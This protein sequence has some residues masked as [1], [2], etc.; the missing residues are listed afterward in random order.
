MFLAQNI[1][2]VED[3]HL[4]AL[5]LAQTVVEQGGHVVGSCATVGDALVMLDRH[6]IDGAILDGTLP[7]GE[8]TPVALRLADRGI[9]M[10]VYSGTGLPTGLAGRF[11]NLPVVFKPAS[12]ATVLAGLAREMGLAQPGRVDPLK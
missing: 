8:V 11:P 1:L 4:I 7:D 9:P 10:I 12:S 6:G 5:D 3:E 2:I